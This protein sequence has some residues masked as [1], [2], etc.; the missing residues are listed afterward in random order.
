MQCSEH[1]IHTSL[2]LFFIIS[3][4]KFLE[5]EIVGYIV[6]IFN[7]LCQGAILKVCT[8]FYSYW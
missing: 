5:A 3:I 7:T 2:Y 6:L 4:I 1:F 8:N